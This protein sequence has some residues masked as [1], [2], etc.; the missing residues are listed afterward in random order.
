MKRKSAENKQT[1]EQTTNPGKRA[2]RS[3]GEGKENT[4][5]I[6]GAVS[7]KEARRTSGKQERPSTQ[8]TNLGTGGTRVRIPIHSET[9]T[10][11]CSQS[12]RQ[13][14]KI[15]AETPATCCTDPS[16]S[17]SEAESPVPADA[18]SN[19]HNRWTPI[20]RSKPLGLASSKRANYM[21]WRG[22]MQAIEATLIHKINAAVTRL[23]KMMVETIET[24]KAQVIKATANSLSRTP[25]APLGKHRVGEEWE[26]S[27]QD[28]SRRWKIT[29]IFRGRST[30]Y[31]MTAMGQDDQWEYADEAEFHQI[32]HKNETY[33]TGQWVEVIQ[34]ARDVKQGWIG[35][36]KET[37]ISVKTSAVKVAFDYDNP[38]RAPLVRNIARDNLRIVS[39]NER[40][41]LIPDPHSWKGRKCICSIETLHPRHSKLVGVPA[42]HPPYKYI[43]ER[44]ISFRQHLASPRPTYRIASQRAN[45]QRAN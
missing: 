32:Y 1:A 9:L 23:T 27:E 26:S 38:H 7:T 37:Q 2:R 6:E 30:V 33:N 12:Q 21:L 31:R 3:V 34:D 11:S 10:D 18:V 45:Q 14:S 36:I 44:V 15:L 16:T 20:A 4:S 41:A 29:D 13:P 19:L 39:G 22:C 35:E 25:V 42:P 17:T 28:G 40:L 8:C 5:N 24:E 43:K